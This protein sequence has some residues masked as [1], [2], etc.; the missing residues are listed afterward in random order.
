MHPE[1]IR[2]GFLE[3]VRGLR[4]AGEERLFPDLKGSKLRSLT[5]AWSQR[6]ARHAR[7]EC[8]ITDSRKVFHSFR[9]LGK[10]EARS[11]MN[12]EHHDAITGH[13]SGSVGRGYGRGVPL[14]VLAESMAKVQFKLPAQTP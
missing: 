1:L 3:F 6:W 7:L 8:G 4:E 10:D 13:S 11:A 9:H 12:E 2:L 14:R 5:T